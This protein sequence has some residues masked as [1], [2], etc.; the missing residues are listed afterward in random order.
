MRKLDERA[1]HART[2][3][4]GFVARQRFGLMR[5]AEKPFPADEQVGDDA[6]RASVKS[7]REPRPASAGHNTLGR[8]RGMPV[9]L[10]GG[11]RH[12]DRVS[13]QIGARIAGTILPRFALPSR[14]VADTS[15]VA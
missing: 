12:S 15:A 2:V 4:L 5:K 7:V 8:T 1:P 3:D 10:P 11:E 6:G 9:R 13:V 14:E